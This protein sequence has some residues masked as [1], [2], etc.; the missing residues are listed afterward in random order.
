MA[1]NVLVV[2]DSAVMRAMII[3]VL[4][5]C[6][7]DLGDVFQAGNG[8]E[9]LEVL[10]RNT[11]DLALVDINMPVMGGE[12]MIDR[13]RADPRTRDL[14]VII[15]STEGS[16]TRIALLREKGAGFVH[17]P[18]TPEVLRG[19]IVGIT[20]EPDDEQLGQRAVS[21]GGYDF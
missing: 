13:L 18:F 19:T 16:D 10:S 20:G 8:Q 1:L 3:K 11:V 15:V 17:K 12:E 9:G 21:G 14:P 7:L 2:D 4:H 6:G 5:L